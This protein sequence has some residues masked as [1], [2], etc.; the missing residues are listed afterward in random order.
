ME[1]KK[2]ILVDDNPDFRFTMGLFLE[3][4]GFDVIAAEDGKTG[5]ERIQAQP[6]DLILLDVMMENLFSGFELCRQIRNSEE[7]K[8]LPI[9]GISA[10]ADEVGVTFDKETDQEYFSPDIFIDK[11]V[12]KELLLKSIHGLLKMA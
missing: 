7:F 5:W 6:P 12:D 11:P 1:K 8:H 9:I 3:R 10:M 4:N 2:I